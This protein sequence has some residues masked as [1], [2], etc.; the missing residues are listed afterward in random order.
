[1]VPEWKW[2]ENNI[3]NI[4]TNTHSLLYTETEVQKAF[5]SR[6]TTCNI[7]NHDTVSFVKRIFQ[8]RMPNAKRF[9]SLTNGNQFYASQT[10]NTL[11]HKSQNRIFGCKTKDTEKK[12]YFNVNMPSGA[13]QPPTT[14]THNTLNWIKEFLYL[15]MKMILI[16]LPF[17]KWMATHIK[18]HLVVQSSKLKAFAHNW[19]GA[20]FNWMTTLIH[21]SVSP[22][23]CIHYIVFYFMVFGALT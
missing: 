6:I 7:R 9:V 20:Y 15:C 10:P 4:T 21:S 14:N 1:M 11:G 2:W 23:S 13:H 22:Y 16:R 12:K 5:Q 18:S 8:C 19:F 17:T 3:S